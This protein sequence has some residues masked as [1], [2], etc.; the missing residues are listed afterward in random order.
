LGAY[1]DKE[2]PEYILVMVANKKSREAM[3]ND[4]QLFLG[5]ETINFIDWLHDLL[6]KCQTNPEG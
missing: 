4:L 2:L 1:V 5:Q 3:A 6:E